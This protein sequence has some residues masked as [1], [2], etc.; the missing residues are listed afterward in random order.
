MVIQIRGLKFDVTD[1]KIILPVTIQDFQIEDD[2]DDLFKIK[3]NFASIMNEVIFDFLDQTEE[4]Q[5]VM[6]FELP[7]LL[8]YFMQK[9]DEIVVQVINKP[10]EVKI[11]QADVVV[12]NKK[13]TALNIASVDGIYTF[14]DQEAILRLDK[15]KIYVVKDGLR[16]KILRFAP[17]MEA[18]NVMFDLR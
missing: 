12:L 14:C 8:R 1:Q 9:L 18:T 3:Y 4:E 11:I 16:F 6:E 10:S 13:V 17:V 15:G 2:D 5:D 7:A